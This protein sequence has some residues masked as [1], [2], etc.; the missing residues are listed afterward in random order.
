MLTTVT[1]GTGTPTQLMANVPDDAYIV[2]L[3]S[4]ATVR[5]ADDP[6]SLPMGGGVP[7]PPNGTGTT[8][9]GDGPVWGVADTNPAQL[10]LTDSFSGYSNPD[11]VAIATATQI[12]QRGVSINQSTQRLLTASGGYPNY[13]S[14]TIDCGSN[15]S[16]IAT[17]TEKTGTAGDQFALLLNWLDSDGSTLIDF[18]PFLV[19]AYGGAGGGAQRGVHRITVPVRARYLQVQIYCPMGTPSWSL[20][21]NGTSA[22][23]GYRCG[24]VGK[25]F[26]LLLT[27]ANQPNITH[28]A[29]ITYYLPPSGGLVT[30]VIQ[31][32]GAPTNSLLMRGY[33][34]TWNGPGLGPNF[35]GSTYPA[36]VLAFYNTQSQD[37]YYQFSVPPGAGI[38]FTIT[39]NDTTGRGPVIAVLDATR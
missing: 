23:L 16:V 19:Y 22:Q 10:V 27:T 6:S 34:L 1:V 18:D 11:A 32:T 3:D 31:G 9:K 12:A 28:G 39:N 14:A 20:I 21:V 30:A 17:L 5:V 7:L 25:N 4:T 26:P 24:Q 36:Q 8:K 2:N 15:Q 33:A 29:T 13:T 37:N 38:S 35:A